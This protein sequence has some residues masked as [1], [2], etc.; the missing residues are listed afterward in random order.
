MM[1]EHVLA[2]RVPPAVALLEAVPILDV[3]VVS[4]GAWQMLRGL[5]L[6]VPE[7]AAFRRPAGLAVEVARGNLGSR[8]VRKT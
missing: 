7:S 8:F 4:R 6:I 2:A 5:L 3:A 1:V